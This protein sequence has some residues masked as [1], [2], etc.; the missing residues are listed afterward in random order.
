[1]PSRS[2]FSRRLLRLS[3]R[4]LLR[5]LS[6]CGLGSRPPVSLFF[7]P[8]NHIWIAVNRIL[9]SPTD[10][11]LPALRLVFTTPASIF[12][13]RTIV[14]I[15]SLLSFIRILYFFSP[16]SWFPTA[17]HLLAQRRLFFY[18]VVS[19]LFLL[20]FEVER[21]LFPAARADLNFTLVSI[22]AFVR[23]PP[24]PFLS[25]NS[26]LPHRRSVASLFP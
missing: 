12:G 5:S 22:M 10:P 17:F 1:L 3:E 9:P 23:L 20:R 21:Y 15:G 2:P 24:A 6:F 26:F 19:S 25:S 14:R 4:S 7:F 18:L 13:G 16:G 11:A 8:P